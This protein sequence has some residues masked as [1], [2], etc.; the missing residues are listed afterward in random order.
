MKGR[1]GDL[2]DDSLGLDPT[3]TPKP[4]WVSPGVHITAGCEDIYK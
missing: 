2:G 1:E 3:D 4:E